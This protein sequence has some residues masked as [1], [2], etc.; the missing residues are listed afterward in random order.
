MGLMIGLGSL[1]FFIFFGSKHNHLASAVYKLLA[2]SQIYMTRSTP[3]DSSLTIRFLLFLSE[4]YAPFV[5]RLVYT[6]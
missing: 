6:A 1:F 2:A 5:A 4:P 3:A